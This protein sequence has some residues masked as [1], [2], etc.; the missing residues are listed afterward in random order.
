[1]KKIFTLFALVALMGARL[2]AQL[3]DGSIVPDFTGTDINGNVWHLYEL[4]DQGKTVVIDVSATWCGPCWNYH[5]TNA[6]EDLY[7][8]Y[9]PNG[10]NEMMVLWVEGDP[11]TGMADL[12]GQT[13][14]SQGDW[15]TG[16]P[17][18]IIDDAAIGDALEIT[19]FPTIYHVCPNRIITEPGQVG[20]SALYAVNAT[21]EVASGNNNGGILKYEGFQGAF[22]QEVYFNPSVKFQNLGLDSIHTASFEL[23]IDG[24]SIQVLDWT[25]AIGT[26]NIVNVEFD[27][28][29][30]TSDANIEIRIVSINGVADEDTSND[31]VTAT[32]SLSTDTDR[33][34]AQVQVTT[35][36]YGVET[37]W[38]IRDGNGNA[39]YSGGNPGIFTGEV[40]P[41][42]YAGNT[43][44]TH[45]VML[46]ANGCYE[47]VVFD[48][49]GDGM[50]CQYGN[51]SFRLVDENNNVL[52][53]GGAFEES[54]AKPFELEG[55]STVDNS[56]R[57]VTYTGAEGAF[58]SSVSFEPQLLVQ[59]QGAN[60]IT[61][62]EIEITING[63]SAG[64]Y[65]WT[66]VAAP[67]DY[68]FVSLNTLDINETADITFTITSINGAADAFAVDN[69]YEVSLIS[70]L[71]TEYQ[72]LT[73]E[74]K[75]DTYGYETFW[76]IRDENGATV[77]SGGNTVVGPNGGGARVAAA[78]N[79]GAYGNNQTVN[80]N[81]TIPA[82]G[83]YELVVVDDWGDGICCQYGN[84]YFRLKEPT[85]NI[86][87]AGGDFDA[88]TE[89][90]FAYQEAV[91]V[92]NLDEVSGLQLFPNPTSDQLSVVFYLSETMPLQIN[93]YNA[94]GQQVQTV[95]AAEYTAG[96]QTINVDASS[97]A[98]GMYYI[99]LQSADKRITKKFVVNR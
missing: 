60:E 16:T 83:C 69:T 96:Q 68:A 27:E 32:T 9:G 77:A 8:T 62:M 57:I 45:D 93:V 65:T 5:N 2:N 53:E 78:G 4:L 91:G 33:N 1:M 72:T 64:T 76:Y 55:A 71:E 54:D 44:Y 40:A 31:S 30:I 26:Y 75:T 88:T 84:G 98:S 3:A 59:N 51:G 11:T 15:V 25:G 49:Y 37:Y 22:C 13:A 43:D 35:D 50:C 74:I 85:G 41:G 23:L 48:A 63:T 95:S 61:S 21:C 86:M 38:E 18:P 14:A 94:L 28:V 70:T 6:L 81:V 10:T 52:L 19:Y 66:G 58:C 87:I 67:G 99:G 34:L 42:A 29:N 89:N 82:S 12:L 36:Q 20:P 7:A 17:Y 46:P 39:L 47:M 79:P 90:P 24:E 56:A 92:R 97:L 73:V 80:T